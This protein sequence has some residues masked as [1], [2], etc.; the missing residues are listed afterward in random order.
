MNTPQNHSRFMDLALDR[1]RE[2]LE[3]GEFPVACLLVD[4]AG[5]L[6]AT[7]ARER[8][9]QG[10]AGELWHAEMTALA[11]LEEFWSREAPGSITAYCTMEPCLMCLGALI[12]HGITRVVYALEDVMGGGTSVDL[13]SL[14]PLYRDSGLSVTGG[15]KRERSLALFQAFFRRP[16]NAYWKDSLLARHILDQPSGDR[17]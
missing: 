16:D 3:A 14:P 1:A 5:R 11:R 7:G 13:A 6:L 9:A 10:P 2:A 17:G 8:T 12:I 15:V 4:D